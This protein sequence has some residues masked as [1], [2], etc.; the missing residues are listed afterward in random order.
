MNGFD[1]FEPKTVAKA[2]ELL[3][4]FDDAKVLAGGVSLLVML[5][6]KLLFPKQIINL[7][8]IKGLDRIERKRDG[9]AVIG[10]LCRHRDI[11][12]SPL[13]KEKYKFLAE[14]ASKIGSPP[15]RNMGT[16][17]GNI[18]HSDPTA[19]LP[20]VLIALNAT[21]KIVSSKGDRT[22]HIH[23]FF[24]NY[25]ENVL[26]KNEIL[27]AIHLPPLPSFAAGS[28]LKLQK[29]ATS[30]SIVGVG[31]LLSVDR[32]CI[33]KCAG[34]GVGACSSTPLKI[35]AMN[36]LI[37]KKVDDN[38]IDSIA[39]AAM[40]QCQPITDVFASARYRRE[41]AGVLVKRALSTTF[42]KSIKQLS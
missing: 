12:S 41:M 21:L 5:R 25:Y 18:C 13:I 34:L 14:A 11:A 39:S 4:K 20:P 33:C 1:Y 8:T 27:T 15:I 9:S 6:N 31:A 32:D 36:R 38:L 40:D 30:V 22:I 7:K 19:D 24:S 10:A 28:Y 3:D 29:T 16:I 2:C 17:G 26:K 23:D 42:E 37:G 35:E